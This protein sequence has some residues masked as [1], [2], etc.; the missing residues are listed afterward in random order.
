MMSVPKNIA[1]NEALN[2]VST[3]ARLGFS[4]GSYV[5]AHL[6]RKR[7]IRV[8]Y[9]S[10]ELRN[11]AKVSQGDIEFYTGDVSWCSEKPADAKPSPTIKRAF[12]SG[13]AC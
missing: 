13:S 7:L 1:Y 12:R 8:D 9:Q 3:A 11:K 4:G 5:R 6:L 2:A 10:D